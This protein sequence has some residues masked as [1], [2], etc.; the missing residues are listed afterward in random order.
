MNINRTVTFCLFLWRG[1]KIK[2]VKKT[3]QIIK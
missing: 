1:F 2:K 3:L